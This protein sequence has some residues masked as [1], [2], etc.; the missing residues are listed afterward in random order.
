MGLLNIVCEYN[1]GEKIEFQAGSMKRALRLC[2]VYLD[3]PGHPYSRVSTH[4]AIAGVVFVNGVLA[5]CIGT[6]PPKDFI[7][8][9]AHDVFKGGF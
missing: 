8:E 5:R 3:N 2:K 4:R 7:S 6:T 1:T 9:Y